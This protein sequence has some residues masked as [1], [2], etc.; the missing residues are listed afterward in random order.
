MALKQYADSV[1]LEFPSLARQ[2]RKETGFLSSAERAAQHPAY[3]RIIQFGQ[4][5]IPLILAE[6]Q[7][8]GGHWFY[9]LRVI[10]NDDPVLPAQRGNV[11]AMTRAWLNWGE[12]HG[13]VYLLPRS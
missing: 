10:T 12:Q 1:E 7:R 8:N 11:A 3:Q 13:Y 2:W 9:A 5:A 6:M 4:L